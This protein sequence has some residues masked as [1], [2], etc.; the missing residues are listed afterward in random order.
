MANGASRRQ[1]LDT[2]PHSH[3][4][5]R[6]GACGQVSNDPKRYR[7]IGLLHTGHCPMAAI[8]K[9]R[10]TALAGLYSSAIGR[11]SAADRPFG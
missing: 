4:C 2:N 11:V 5:E 9:G 7:L 3:C 10:M 6:M 8:G 1:L